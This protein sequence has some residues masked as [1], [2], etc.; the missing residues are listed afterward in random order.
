MTEQFFASGAWTA[1]T[2]GETLAEA[3]R[4]AGERVAV[5]VR[6]DRMTWADLGS[7]PDHLAAGLLDLGLVPGDRIIFQMGTGTA[8]VIAFHAC[9]KAG[10]VPVCAVP[11]YRA[12]EIGAL[13]SAAGPGPSRRGGSAGG[14]DLV[15]FADE[16]RAAHPGCVICS[17]PCHSA[18]RCPDPGRAGSS[19]EPLEPGAGSSPLDEAAATAED[20]SPSS[21]S[22]G[23]DGDSKIIPRSTGSI[24][25]T[26]PVVRAGRADR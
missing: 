20:V 1:S 11:A 21:F 18:G 24:W 16:Q 13:M 9:W 4:V 17:W 22:G 25:P 5:V 15:A 8:I 2:M 23:V 12:Y 19:R 26:R 6:D 10:L 7:P 14:F 3:A